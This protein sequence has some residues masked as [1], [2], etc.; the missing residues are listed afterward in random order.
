MTNDINT[1]NTAT[2]LYKFILIN[3]DQEVVMSTHL[4]EPDPAID[5]EFWATFMSGEYAMVYT[6]TELETDE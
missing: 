5:A 1:T 6:G 4:E 3:E 2:T